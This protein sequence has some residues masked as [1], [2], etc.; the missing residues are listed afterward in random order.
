MFDGLAGGRIKSVTE[1]NFFTITLLAFFYAS[2]ISICRSTRLSQC[3]LRNKQEG[4]NGKSDQ[5]PFHGEPPKVWDSEGATLISFI[6][7]LDKG[8]MAAEVERRVE[9]GHRA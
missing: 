6:P 1:L 5:E 8:Q 7:S 2:V 9:S 3:D 4:R